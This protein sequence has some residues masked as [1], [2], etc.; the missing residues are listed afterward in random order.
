M[1]FIY[2]QYCHF[3]Q[4]TNG[5]ALFQSA[6]E[7]QGTFLG[8]SGNFVVSRHLSAAGP[9]R[10]HLSYRAAIVEKATTDICMGGETLIGRLNVAQRILGT[11]P[12]HIMSRMVSNKAATPSQAERSPLTGGVM[13]PFC[14]AVCQLKVQQPEKTGRA[15]CDVTGQHTAGLSRRGHSSHVGF[16]YPNV[17]LQLVSSTLHLTHSTNQPQRRTWARHCLSMTCRFS[18]IILLP[19]ENATICRRATHIDIAAR[20]PRLLS[21]RLRSVPTVKHGCQQA[22]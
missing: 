4:P 15:V 3:L 19:S 22:L 17:R 12:S 11:I 10:T 20:Y 2:I 8:C 14:R 5:K 7:V 9:A 6:S 16:F 1:S 18:G 13:L 21:Y